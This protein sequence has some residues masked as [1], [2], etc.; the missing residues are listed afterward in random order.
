MPWREILYTRMDLQK[1]KHAKMAG[2][3]LENYDFLIFVTWLIHIGDMTYS[4]ECGMRMCIYVCYIHTCICL[5]ESVFVKVHTS[6][7][8]RKNECNMWLLC[9]SVHDRN[10]NT[11]SFWYT[12]IC[13]SIY[14]YIYAYTYT[15]CMYTYVHIYICIYAYA[16]CAPAG[17]WQK[18]IDKTTV[19][20]KKMAVHASVPSLGLY[21]HQRAHL[22][23]TRGKMHARVLALAA[24]NP[25]HT[26]GTERKGQVESEDGYE[27]WGMCAWMD[28]W[29]AWSLWE[30]K[31]TGREEQ[32]STRRN[33]DCKRERIQVCVYTYIPIWHLYAI[34]KCICR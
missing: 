18:I 23:E 7:Q 26:A 31:Q 32:G 5:N 8:A 17:Q 6:K 19:L 9:M 30:Q 34:Y 22:W 29:C 10:V 4:I 33:T 27:C 21:E 1:N 13:T 25:E 11:S 28:I 16:G 15:Y 14:I 12:Y 3:C 20:P 24:W 2:M